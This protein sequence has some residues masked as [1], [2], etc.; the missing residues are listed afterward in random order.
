VKRNLFGVY[1][2]YCRI[3]QTVDSTK[4][5]SF[6]RK[7]DKGCRRSIS[8]PRAIPERNY[9]EF[10]PRIGL[11]WAPRDKCPYARVTAFLTRHADAENYTD[12]SLGLGFIPTTM[13][14]GVHHWK[15][16]MEMAVGPPLA[17][18]S[19]LLYKLFRQKSLT[20]AT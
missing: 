15:L 13:V 6:W 20:S 2:P 18:S 3:P 8:N 12:G 10:A 14:R 9:K 11:A 19:F 7:S 1:D 16:S 17:R 4:G 5:P